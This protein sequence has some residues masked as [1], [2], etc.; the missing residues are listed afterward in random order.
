[1]ESPRITPEPDE[2]ERRAILA[3]LAA[4][5]A[6]RR[7]ASRRAETFLPGNGSQDDEP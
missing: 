3:A 2:G 7:K 6:E 1:M 4:E 5:E